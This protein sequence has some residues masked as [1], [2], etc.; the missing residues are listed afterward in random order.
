LRRVEHFLQLRRG[1]Q[2][3]RL[4]ATGQELEIARRA[5]EGDGA[6]SH[7]LKAQVQ[8]KM[9]VVA[10]ICARVFAEQQGRKRQLGATFELQSHYPG[11]GDASNQR[12]LEALAVSAPAIHQIAT[13]DDLSP[14]A[15][16]NLFRF[17]ESAFTSSARFEI[18]VAHP[19][20]LESSLC[21]FEGSEYLSQ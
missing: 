9:E 8:A 12:L 20:A 11:L 16:K 4:P 3:H 19:E 1:H 18:V 17:L 21:L 13:R 2:T 10:E 7:E 6:S 15:R 14:V 5:I